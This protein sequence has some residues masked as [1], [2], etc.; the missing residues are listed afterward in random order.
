M[1]V[2][3]G[4]VGGWSAV[5]KERTARMQWGIVARRKPG[6]RVTPGAC[7]DSRDA[8]RLV[9]SQLRDGPGGSG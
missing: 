3:L 4:R 1:S 6:I 2:P 5:W 9:D 7:I 8:I